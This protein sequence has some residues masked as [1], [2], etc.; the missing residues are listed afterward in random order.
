VEVAFISNSREEKLLK[1]ND[2]NLKAA[3]ALFDGLKYYIKN[4]PE[5]G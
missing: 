1:N 3:Q 2:F 5:E 4:T